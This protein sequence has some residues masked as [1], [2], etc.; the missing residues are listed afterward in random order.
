MTNRNVPPPLPMWEQ[1]LC[2]IT[3]SVTIIYMF[4][5]LYHA[6]EDS[7]QKNEPIQIESGWAMIGRPMD[8]ADDEWTFWSSYFWDLLPWMC[9]HVLVSCVCTKYIGS[10]E[11]KAFLYSL[12]GFL[13]TCYLLGFWTVVV[14]CVLPVV[15]CMVARLGSAAAVWGVS[16]VFLTFLNFSENAML[17]WTRSYYPDTDLEAWFYVCIFAWGGLFQ[18]ST[19]FALECV[20]AQQAKAGAHPPVP[21]PLPQV[22]SWL[23]MLFYVFY[24]P[25]FFTGPLMIYNKFHRQFREPQQWSNRRL[26]DIVWKLVR[27][28]FWAVMNIVIL[29]FIYPHA[30]NGNSTVLAQQ[31]RMTIAAIGYSLGQLFMV[32]YLV[33]FGLPAQLARLDGFEPPAVPACISYIYCYSDMWRAFDRGLYDFMTRYIFIPLGGSHAGLVYRVTGSVMCF[34]FVYYWHGAEFFLFLW[35]VL[36]FVETSLEQLGAWLEKTDIVRNAIYS[37]LSP[38]AVRRVRAVMSVPMF[39]MSV[40]AIF[41]FFGGTGSGLVFLRKLLIDIPWDSFAVFLTLV[42]CAVQNAMEVERLGLTKVRV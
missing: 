31:S 11:I 17:Q 13:A 28:L 12:Y 32:K 37:N 10:P 30:I 36:N 19:A 20:W 33:L 41:Y 21:H 38:A 8:S 18:R 35:C 16:L 3:E 1:C 22:P 9:G 25:L 34:A 29:H 23:D 4:Y 7:R 40:F 26:Q 5:S 15:S 14:F 2:W 39:L 27:I 42:Y 6:S 24:F